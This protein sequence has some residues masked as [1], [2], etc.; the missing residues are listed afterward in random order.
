MPRRPNR[1]D[2]DDD[3]PS[4]RHPRKKRGMHWA[5]PLLIAAG[6][7][8]LVAAG[9]LIKRG[10]LTRGEGGAASPTEVVQQMARAAEQKDWN[11]AFDL[12]DPESRKQVGDISREWLRMRP[13]YVD[14]D[15]RAAYCEVCRIPETFV[16]PPH[17]GPKTTV[18]SETITGDRAVVT[19]PGFV[20]PAELACV[21]RG[22]KWYLTLR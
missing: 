1:Y 16:W 10:G 14:M 6:V 21:K 4:R 3:R 22:N 5:V 19:V 17:I 15:D 2:H 9:V 11:A 8:G 7:L 18:L 20:R 12:I 13:G